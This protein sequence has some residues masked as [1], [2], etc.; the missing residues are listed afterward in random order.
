MKQQLHNKT[1]SVTYQTLQI[2]FISFIRTSMQSLDQIFNSH[3]TTIKKKMQGHIHQCS[4]C[5]TINKLDV[6]GWNA[7]DVNYSQLGAINNA[8]EFQVYHC[9]SSKNHLSSILHKDLVMEP[10]MP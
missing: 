2:K 3:P 6:H 10:N 4:P 5:Y 9:C 8:V 7:F 1:A